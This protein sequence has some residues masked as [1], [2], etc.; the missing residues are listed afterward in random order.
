MYINRHISSLLL[1]LFAHFPIVVVSGARQVGK[2]TLIRHLMGKSAEYAEF[3]PITDIEGAREDPD[4]F[5]DNHHTPLILDEIQYAPELASALKRRVDRNDTP[6]QYLLSGSQQWAMIRALSES[7]AGR[8]VFV[9]LMHFSITEIS[10]AP[11]RR[12]W[13]C[14]WFE[15]R[16]SGKLQAAE[17]SFTLYEQL[18]RGFLPKVQFLPERLVF[19]YH[20]S[21]ERT[22]I[23]RDIR[24]LSEPSD[25]QNFSNFFRLL[26]ALTAQEI[27]Y[28]QLGRE[29]ALHPQTARRWIDLCKAT[30]QWFEL[31]A[32][33]ANTIKR[34]SS[35]PKGI[36][37]D[38]GI[39]CY[40]QSISSP[41]A[42]AA[43]PLTG[44]LFESAVIAEIK[45]QL[46]N[47]A[48][49]ASLYHW[50][51]HAGAEVDCIVERD[52]T[53]YPFEI[54]LNSGPGKKDARGIEAFRRTFPNAKIG[55]GAIIAPCASAYKVTHN[56]WV[57]P[58]NGIIAE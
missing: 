44:R 5:L 7:L 42:L 26:G 20:K 34:L 15:N 22:Y 17:Q 35:R 4:L 12:H 2:S 41:G 43:H 31:P 14:T 47:C 40:A 33:H 52:G 51:T 56:D 24:T 36:I 39:A 23:E 16:F 55:P 48:I 32:F 18:W 29:F 37:A 27:N 8:A 28:A 49:N 9:D 25:L 58:W 21:Y 19:S 50:R 46:N 54:K 45:K 1:D 3:D 10:E 30:Y 13:L 53:L 6:G 11:A 38:T 57:I